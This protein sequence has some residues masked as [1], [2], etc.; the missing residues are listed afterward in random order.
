MPND[1][2]LISGG[3]GLLGS[4]FRKLVLGAIAPTHQEMDVLD[5][6]AIDRF[7]NKYKPSIFIH[8]AAFISPPKCDA[9]PMMA[10]KNNIFGTCNVVEAC[11]KHNI[12]LVYLSTDYVF[13]GDRGDYKGEDELYPQNLYA[14]TKLGGECAVR[15]YTNSLIIRTSFCPE[16]FPYNK[17]FVDQYT[18][19][20]SVSVIAPMILS[21]AKRKDVKGV[22]HVGT[23]RKTVRELALKLGKH[24]V[25]SLT[26]SKVSFNAPFDTSFNLE[27]LKSILL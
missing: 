22:I 17:A 11:H 19:R 13:K 10:M 9:E 6:G 15:T 1:R 25:G 12:R 14:W 20:D 21:L 2:I 5:A 8:A 3:S 23:E 26:R 18:S 24:N 4:C 16:I 27:K 7:L